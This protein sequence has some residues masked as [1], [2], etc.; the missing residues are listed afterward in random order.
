MERR[1]PGVPDKG[2]SSQRG[3]GG[4]SMPC[5]PSRGHAPATRGHCSSPSPNRGAR[6]TIV[7]KSWV[8]GKTQPQRYSCGRAPKRQ[9]VRPCPWV[10]QAVFRS[11]PEIC[12]R[13]NSREEFCVGATLA[14][15]TQDDWKEMDKWGRRERQPD[16]DSKS[17]QPISKLTPILS[18]EKPQVQRG[19]GGDIARKQRSLYFKPSDYL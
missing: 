12:P 13:P 5:H 10:P 8:P 4:P 11:L 19:A 2:P 15:P 6:K 1:T 7:W 3:R 9:R 18:A 17:T 14:R 16:Q